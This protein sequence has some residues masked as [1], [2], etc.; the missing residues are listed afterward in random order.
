MNVGD[1]RKEA[2]KEGR[3]SVMEQT[4]ILRLASDTEMFLSLNPTDQEAQERTKK[5]DS[6]MEGIVEKAMER[7][8][9]IS[10]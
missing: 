9:D 3:Y 4:L 6:I 7:E 1:L 2:A 10:D 5:V 8:G